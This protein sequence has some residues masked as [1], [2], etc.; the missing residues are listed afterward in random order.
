MR[1]EVSI[2]WLGS[3]MLTHSLNGEIKGLNSFPAGE[4]P[5]VGP[6]FFAFRI[7]VG[8]G[9][10]ML[11]LVATGTAMRRQGRFLSSAW[12]LR[13]C[14]WAAPLGFAAVLAGWTVTE[15]GRQ[16]WT[17]YGL[18]RTADSVSPSLT[19]TDVLLTLIGYVAV[20]L[21]IYPGG[22][23]VMARIVRHGP[24]APGTSAVP[25]ATPGSPVE[26]GRPALPVTALHGLEV[27]R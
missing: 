20:Y 25:D 3:L 19:G 17:V 14:Q 2:P 16:P 18:L 26:S 9:V 1:H 11:A 23:L 21:I 6:A 22:L 13:A 10:L 24:A 7:M 15:S 27:A 12:F 4:R 5:P 8:I